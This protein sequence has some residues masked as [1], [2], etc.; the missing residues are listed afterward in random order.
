MDHHPAVDVTDVEVLGGHRVRITFN[1]GAVVTRDLSPLLW[2]PIFEEIRTDPQK[3]GAVAI[4]CELGVL[5]WPNGADLDSEMLRY[6][7]LWEHTIALAPT[8]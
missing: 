6:D 5:S 8:A 1:D 7:D 3:F 2:G 4:D